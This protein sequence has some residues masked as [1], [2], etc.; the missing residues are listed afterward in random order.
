[1]TLRWVVSLAPES[2]PHLDLPHPQ[3]QPHH[4]PS[5]APR[6]F[7]CSYLY[8]PISAPVVPLSLVP[9]TINPP[10]PSYQ[11]T[12]RSSNLTQPPFPSLF[13]PLHDIL[14]TSQFDIRPLNRSPAVSNQF[15]H[16]LQTQRG[17]KCSR[18]YPGLRVLICCSRR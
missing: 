12:Y 1:M 11:G 4:L 3:T 5:S 13:P 14:H 8:E 10:S 2:L 6:Q 16:I 9:P 15:I 18:G 17:Q 7:F